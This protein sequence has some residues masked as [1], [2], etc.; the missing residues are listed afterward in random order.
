[1]RVLSA[2]LAAGVAIS[3][4]AHSVGAADL[5][6]ELPREALSAPPRYGHDW[7]GFYIGAGVG[8]RWT[9]VEWTT[10]GLGEG[11]VSAVPF[12]T[13]NPASFDQSGSRISGYAGYNWQVSRW[14]LG[15]EADVGWSD[16]RKTRT[17]IPG[18]LAVVS[19]AVTDTASVSEEWDASIRGRLGFLVTPELLLYGTAGVAWTRRDANAS[20]AS[21]LAPVSWC[22][23]RPDSAVGQPRFQSVTENIIGWTAG[24]GLEWKLASNWTLRGEYRYADYGSTAY[25]F[26]GSSGDFGSDQVFFSLDHQSH[27]AYLGLSYLLPPAGATHSDMGSAPTIASNIRRPGAGHDWSGFYIGPH[28]G[29][30]A[31]ETEWIDTTRLLAPPNIPG[32]AIPLDP[33]GVL[34]GGQVGFNSQR[35]SWVFG[36]EAQASWSNA[37]G[38]SIPVVTPPPFDLRQRLDTD[39][40]WL[41]TFTGRIGYSIDRSL[42]YLKGGLALIDEDHSADA[43]AFGFPALVKGAGGTRSGWVVGGGVEW[44]IAT[45]WSARLEYNFMDFGRETYNVTAV[46]PDLGVINTIPFDVDQQIH[47]VTFGINYR[48]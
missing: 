19:P 14:V 18:T 26:Y 13:N 15:V 31:A 41:A 34:A 20:C 38:S 1:M 9:D 42:L 3:G 33:V 32:Y 27:T 7:S 16:T 35:G 48:F 28:I 30:L 4:V 8:G 39:I 24:G 6:G 2:G 12:A 36:L 43:T 10:T 40:N 44:V 21:Q 46:F 17:G 29:G 23:P 5:G 25:A 37:S 11:T 22:V 47:S 45:N